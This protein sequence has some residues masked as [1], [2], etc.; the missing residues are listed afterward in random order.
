V[1]YYGLFPWGVKIE[2]D[3]IES[4]GIDNTAASY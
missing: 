3:T 4:M 2:V 1:P